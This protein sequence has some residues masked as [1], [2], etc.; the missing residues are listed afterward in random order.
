MATLIYG[1]NTVRAALVSSKTK[2]IYVSTSFNDKKLLALAQK[3]GIT[4]KV[5]SNQILDAMVKGTH[6]GIVAEVER[7]EYS[8]LDD[9]IRESKKVTRPI[10][11]LLDG[12]NDPGNFGAILRS[13]DAFGVSGVIIKKHGQVMLNAT[14]AKTST[15]AI[16]YVKVAMV[17]NLSQAIERLK[18]EN[19]WIVSSE[20]GS[21]T[22]YQDLKYDFP[23]A[24]V[25]GSEGEG[26]SP[27]LI[28][29]SDFVVKIPMKGH[30]N[31]LNASVATG[32]LLS[33]INIK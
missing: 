21:D 23:V 15:G 33:Y 32:I 25:I 14:V 31:S 27:L 17:T 19:F 29:R 2:N 13:C 20:G 1:R 9:I 10:V 11:L 5:V 18:K 30:V 6:Q 4:I 7:Y 24:L 8:S 3:E 28:K 12:I 22:N 26:I 16:N